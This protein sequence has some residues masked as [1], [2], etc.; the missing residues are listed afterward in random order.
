MG[1]LSLAQLPFTSNSTI[2]ASVSIN[3]VLNDSLLVEILQRLPS[4]SVLRAK[5]VCKHWFSLLSD[6]CF[7]QS[8]VRFHD[9][10][11][12]PFTLVY[13]FHFWH[14]CLS[15][16]LHHNFHMVS[17]HKKFQLQGFHLGFLPCFR[18]WESHPI[19]VVA[20]HKDLLVCCHL[21]MSLL[22]GVYYICN[23]LTK[24]WLNLPPSPGH[25]RVA[26]TAIGFITCEKSVSLNSFKLVQVPKLDSCVSNGNC[27][28]VNVFSS[29]VGEWRNFKISSPQSFTRTW[30][31]RPESITVNNKFH[32][33][34]NSSNIVVVDPFELAEGSCRVI[35]LPAEL[36]L[37]IGICLGFCQDYLRVCQISRGWSNCL[38]VVWKLLDYVTGNW[39]LEYETSLKEMAFFENVSLHKFGFSTMEA[40]A[41]HPVDFG[42]LYLRFNNQ[43][44]MCDVG[45][46]TLEV[47]S[48]CLQDSSFSV[49][50]CGVFLLMHPCWPSLIPSPLS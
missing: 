41:F 33:L 4:I 38:L 49:G 12:L 19:W 1:E 21:K 43:I 15:D 8:F 32:W 18:P 13:E 28:E 23:P 36:N 29:E 20:C 39:D 42:I 9:H 22:Q 47:V 25:H 6:P 34:V 5:S 40:L 11:A 37:D 31:F 17:E 35:E 24:Q 2:S 50:T 3:N 7:L 10:H 44:V 30:Q 48:E 27:F 26:D 16:H 46:K 14:R 45:R